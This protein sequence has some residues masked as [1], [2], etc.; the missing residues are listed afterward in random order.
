M[1]KGAT[2]QA[3]EIR[4]YEI[5]NHSTLRQQILSLRHHQRRYLP[6]AALHCRPINRELRFGL[7]PFNSQSHRKIDIL[8]WKSFPAHKTPHFLSPWRHHVHIRRTSNGSTVFLPLEFEEF[9]KTSGTPPAV[10]SFH[11]ATYIPATSENSFGP[12]IFV[13]GG[14]FGFESWHAR[15]TGTT[16]FLIN[17]LLIYYLSSRGKWV[18]WRC[19]CFKSQNDDVA[20]CPSEEFYWF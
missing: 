12:A 19:T 11:T 15:Y 7:I 6:I 2:P 14:F 3:T 17:L 18:S 5:P 13:F 16:Q 8:Q 4:E 10:R 1:A 20:S 9:V